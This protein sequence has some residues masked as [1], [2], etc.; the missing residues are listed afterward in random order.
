MASIKV[1]PT[2]N[3]HDIEWDVKHDKLSDLTTVLYLVAYGQTVSMLLLSILVIFFLIDYESSFDI[4]A[5]FLF[6]CANL[7]GSTVDVYYTKSMILLCELICSVFMCT[8]GRLYYLG[9]RTCSMNN[10]G[11]HF[12]KSW[13]EIDLR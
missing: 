10:L 2:C 9:L 7:F 5:L 11:E 12:S 1:L 13:V 8:Q 6:F 3:N 4:L